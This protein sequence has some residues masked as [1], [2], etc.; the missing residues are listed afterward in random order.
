MFEYTFSNTYPN[1]KGVRSDKKL[2]KTKKTQLPDF[3]KWRAS[4]YY[5]NNSKNEM[6]IEVNLPNKGDR[7]ESRLKTIE[8]F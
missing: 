7:E 5:T 6:Q 3:L 4:F 8:H 2:D 1:H